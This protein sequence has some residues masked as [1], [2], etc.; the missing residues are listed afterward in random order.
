MSINVTF[1]FGNVAELQEFLGK[2]EV[3]P[4][5]GKIGVSEIS[6]LEW[7]LEQILPSKSGEL[8]KSAVQ[9]FAADEKFSIPELA[10]K[11]EL[12]VEKV[13]SWNRT[14]SHSCET[15]KF[16]KSDLLK[17]HEGN[18]KKFS[19]PPEVYAL[20]LSVSAKQYHEVMAREEEDDA[21]EEMSP[22]MLAKL[23]EIK[24]KWDG[25]QK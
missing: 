19:I 1:Q 17:E 16:H 5:G 22:E 24:K 21:D 10:E 7:L 18:P 6:N 8:L 14:L 4:A 15:R 13:L 25:D 9:G 20:I 12:P 3:K 11:F 2:V 23:Q